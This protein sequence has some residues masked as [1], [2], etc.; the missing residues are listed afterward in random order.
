MSFCIDL[1]VEHGGGTSEV[2]TGSLSHG[3]QPLVNTPPTMLW[4]PVSSVT[5]VPIDLGADG[6]QTL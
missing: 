1:V 5:G 2:V 3:S 6:R 4:A